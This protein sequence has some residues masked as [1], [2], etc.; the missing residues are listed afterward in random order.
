GFTYEF[1]RCS[2]YDAGPIL[3]CTLAGG[4]MICVCPT[5]VK[6]TGMLDLPDFAP[7]KVTQATRA[8]TESQLASFDH[9]AMVLP[10][11]PPGSAYAD[12]PQGKQLHKL[13]DRARAQGL[14]SAFTRLGNSRATG[15]TAALLDGSTPFALLNWARE[16]LADCLRERPARLAL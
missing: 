5:R 10:K 7:L 16:V 15:V 3:N 11:E 9:V 4:A 13:I 8:F 6:A 2:C 14:K 1:P 12:L